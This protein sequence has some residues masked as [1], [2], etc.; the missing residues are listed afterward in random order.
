MY[1]V[2]KQIPV[3]D[4]YIAVGEIVDGSQWRNLRGLVSSRYLAPVLIADEVKPAKPKA[5]QIAKAVG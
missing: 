2:L 5:T 3:K 4:G 1:Q